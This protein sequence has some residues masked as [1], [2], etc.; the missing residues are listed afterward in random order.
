MC[1]IIKQN[2]PNFATFACP[3]FAWRDYHD[4]LKA[5]GCKHCVHLTQLSTL[6]VQKLWEH[7]ESHHCH[8]NGNEKLS[9]RR[10]LNFF[11]TVP[12]KKQ[13]SVWN[14]EEHARKR[15]RWTGAIVLLQP[16]L[17]HGSPA[18]DHSINYPCFAKSH[19]WFINDDPWF[20]PWRRMKIHE[21]KKIMDELD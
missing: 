7:G 10:N 21:L 15:G 14:K 19:G 18:M 12:Q 4:I 13:K 6:P 3:T 17:T 2:T 1:Q 11:N 8:L 20:H 5:V 9:C 16:R